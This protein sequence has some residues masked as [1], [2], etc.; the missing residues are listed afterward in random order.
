MPN[1][2]NDLQVDSRAFDTP[3]T[4]GPKLH[5]NIGLVVPAE[6]DFVDSSLALGF[7]GPAN[8]GIAH[9]V[10][11]TNGTLNGA[12]HVNGPMTYQQM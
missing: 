10:K 4:S 11:L 5:A 3:K 7:K 1:L 2:R 6:T 12:A 9:K 8:P